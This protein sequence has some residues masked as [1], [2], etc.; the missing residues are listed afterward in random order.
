M[1]KA[2][3]ANSQ[4]HITQ[5]KKNRESSFGFIVGFGVG[6]VSGEI[7][8]AQR[9]TKCKGLGGCVLC[10]SFSAEILINSITLL[11]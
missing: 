10:H 2:N 8:L 3:L 9:A 1:S 4:K 6:D 5:R 7:P 11:L